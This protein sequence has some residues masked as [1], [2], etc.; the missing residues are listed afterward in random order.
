MT[1]NIDKQPLDLSMAGTKKKIKKLHK[2]LLNLI[3]SFQTFIKWGKGSLITWETNIA[4]KVPTRGKWK[5]ILDVHV[6]DVLGL[7][8]KTCMVGEL[9]RSA[10]HQ[11]PIENLAK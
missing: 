5:K 2:L 4:S 3:H 1:S 8:H 11:H 6:K 9:K 7:L 10:E